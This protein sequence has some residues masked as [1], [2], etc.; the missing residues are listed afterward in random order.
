MAEFGINLNLQLSG[1]EKFQRAIRTVEELEAA[2][3]RA[4]KELDLSGKLPGRGAEA[5]KIGTLTKKMNDLAT[6]LVTAGESGKKT[7]AG[8]SD[9][10]NSFRSLAK[11]SDVTRLSFKNFVEATVVAEKEV[12]KFARAEENVRRAFLG[13]QTLEEREAQLERRANTLRT[14]R[15]RKKLKEQEA[16]AREEN[17]RAI[18]READAAAR[19]NRQKEREAQLAKRR[20]GRAV[21]DLAASIGFPLLFGGGAGSVTG[22]AIGSLIGSAAGIGFGGQILGS[23]LGQGLDQAAAAANEFALAA[24]KAST[25]I[26][27]LVQGFGLKGTGSASTLR[28]AETLGIGGAA[29]AAA[30]GGLVGIVGEQGAKNLE[31]LAQSAEDAGNALNR[32]GAATTSFFSPL[33]TSLNQAVA[34]LF[35]GISKI[36]QL[37]RATDPANQPSAVVAGPGAGA[38]AEFQR[39]KSA[40]ITALADDPE[41]KAQLELQEKINKVVNDRID[42][43]EQATALENSRLSSRRDVFA[44][45]QG[46]LAVQAQ[47]N[48]LDV[49]AIQL[50]GELTKQKRQELKL[51]QSLTEEAKRQ[52]E[53]ARQNALVEAQRQVRRE[54]MSGAINQIQI[55]EKEQRLE[56][57]YQQAREGRFELFDAEVKQ[58]ADEFDSNQGIIEL[59]RKRALIG[60]TEAERISSINRDYDLKARLAEKQF[61]I[62][63]LNLQQANAAY[64][65]SRLQV[66]QALELQRIQAATSAQQQI[67][68]TS[69]FA[70]TAELLD[71]YFG[72]S[73]QLE[74][75]QQVAF[76]EQLDLMDAQLKDVTE[77]LEIFALSPTVRKGLEDQEAKI[78]DQIANFKEYQPAIDQAALAQMRFNEA[79]A[80]TVPV[81]DAVFDNLL[82]IVDGTKTA[83]EAFADFLRSISQLL[84]DAAKQMIATYIS[85]GI[86]RMFAGMGDP[87]S[88]QSAASYGTPYIGEFSRPAI[89]TGFA[90]G[91]YV[92]SPTKAVIGEGGESEYVIPESKMRESMARYSRG[93]RGAS[94]IPESGEAG[95][96]GGG[97]GTA[98]AA[99]IDVRYTVE[100]INDVEYVTAAQF[101]AGMQ[102]AAAQGAQR[103]EQQ[104]LRRLQ[105]SGSTRR[106]IGL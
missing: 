85:I 41:V 71:P 48:K 79:M 32:F 18:K 59:E 25:S 76:R 69:P 31:V 60:V 8:I 33:L 92:S 57:Q 15:T 87:G 3:K 20:K 83:E 28:F 51:E 88:G 77:Q 64:Q 99:P 6:K 16:R 22:G 93:A 46:N 90:Q 13:M 94:V 14:L 73:R 84:M 45:E 2:V 27:T 52:A 47:Q 36:E 42:L 12:E 86:A 5:D 68:Q 67:R 74:I 4:S 97:G 61:N 66:K 9:L 53:A 75:D 21:G 96:V 100:R 7:Q 63:K 40:K 80:I 24:T 49:I 81:T 44:L 17:A 62:D 23:A 70:R 50:A 95:T 34:G 72:G 82:A 104:T 101:Q 35:G 65:L 19:L 37:E 1:Q 106:R 54:Q 11:I 55:L 102:Q 26:D 78:K 10:T 89:T 39:A 58:L 91:G 56:L 30:Q 105:M 98:V 38:R 103:G 43:A 29:R